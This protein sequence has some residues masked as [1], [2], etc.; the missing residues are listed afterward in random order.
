MTTIK[1]DKNARIKLQNI[2]K[3]PFKNIRQFWAAL[4]LIIDRDTMLTFRHEGARGGHAAWTPFA[5]STLEMLKTRAIGKI[6]YGTDL[7]GRPAGTYI[8]FKIRPGMRR[9]S[10]S[11][12][13]LQAGGMFRDSFGIV[14]IGRDRL[15]YGTKHEKAEKIM[16]VKNRQVLFVTPQDEQRYATQFRTWYLKGLRI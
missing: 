7:R 16:G 4:A 13:L 12:K 10:A 1:L 9:Y 6:R 11:S 15:I 3:R 5:R 8:P 14:K 2:I